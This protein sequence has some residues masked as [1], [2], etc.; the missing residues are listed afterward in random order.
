MEKS[1]SIE[2]IKDKQTNKKKKSVKD[3]AKSKKK[4]QKSQ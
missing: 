1:H 4:V 3:N 2:I